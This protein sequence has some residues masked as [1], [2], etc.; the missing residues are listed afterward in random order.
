MRRNANLFVA[1]GVRVCFRT[2]H[3]PGLRR[4]CE[5]TSVLLR[6][7][8]SCQSTILT[9]RASSMPCPDHGAPAFK[10]AAH[11]NQSP[12]HRVCQPN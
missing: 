11:V 4:A 8:T 9:R 2:L 12:S 3:L 1:T 6:Q 10:Q 7:E 5:D